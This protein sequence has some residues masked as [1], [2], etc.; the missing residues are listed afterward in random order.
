MISALTCGNE[1]AH[2]AAEM[3][4]QNPKKKRPGNDLL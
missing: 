1:N 2:P 4:M 3:Q